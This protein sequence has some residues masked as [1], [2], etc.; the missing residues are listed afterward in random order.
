[1]EK[2]INDDI[3]LVGEANFSF[4]LS[5]LKYCHPKFVTTSCYENKETALKNTASI[6]SQTT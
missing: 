3:L 4:T 6:L 1:M 2:N 5:L